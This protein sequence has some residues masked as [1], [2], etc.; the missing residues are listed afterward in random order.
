MPQKIY[1]VQ[2]FA[3]RCAHFSFASA[4]GTCEIFGSGAASF[5]QSGAISGPPACIAA[6]KLHISGVDFFSLSES[7]KEQLSSALAR[8]LARAAALPD[9]RGD[10]LSN[11]T[12][13]TPDSS[14]V[15]NTVA[16]YGDP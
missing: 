14:K 3:P 9:I 5:N 4:S 7:A 15:A 13:L 8:D 6:V 10:H 16:K 11:T 12:C 2:Y 1:P